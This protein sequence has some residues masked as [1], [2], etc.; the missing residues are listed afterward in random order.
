MSL[1]GAYNL[2]GARRV[3]RLPVVDP[4]GKL[5]GI[6]TKSDIQQVLPFVTEEGETF[7]SIASIAGMTVGEIMASNPVAVTPA[8]AVGEAAALMIRHQVS[9]LPVVQADRV[10]GIIT[11]S[12]IF[13]LVVASWGGGADGTIKEATEVAV[14]ERTSGN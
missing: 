10:V 6:I 4:E 3:R 14:Y 5:A 9:G 11:E 8:Q 13:K 1:I 2:M 7:D 12:D